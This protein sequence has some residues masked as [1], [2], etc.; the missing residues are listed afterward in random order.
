M[1]KAVETAVN[2]ALAGVN[3]I[4]QLRDA[5]REELVNRKDKAKEKLD[6][7]MLTEA[8]CRLIWSASSKDESTNGHIDP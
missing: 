6:I 7:D 1:K 3:Q 2:A 8:I 5:M 4:R